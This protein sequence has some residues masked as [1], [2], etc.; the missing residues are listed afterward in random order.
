MKNAVVVVLNAQFKLR[1]QLEKVGFRS[2]YM[3][4]LEAAAK[5]PA[6]SLNSSPTAHSEITMRVERG[7]TSETA[8]PHE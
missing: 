8:P 5:K 3:F 4:L 6:V 1:L 7:I 2:D